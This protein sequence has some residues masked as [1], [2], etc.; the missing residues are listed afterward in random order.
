MMRRVERDGGRRLD[1]RV[2]TS[3]SSSLSRSY[4]FYSVFN[5]G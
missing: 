3:S 5:S 4:I 2:A 1:M